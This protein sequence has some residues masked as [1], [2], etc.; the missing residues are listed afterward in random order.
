MLKTNLIY[1]ATEKHIEKYLSAKTMST[2]SITSFTAA[3]G[4]ELSLL[5]QE[6]LPQEL[7]VTSRLT[8]F[9]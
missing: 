4:G 8:P 1:P 6:D 5:S 3:T 7:N 2:I 9:P